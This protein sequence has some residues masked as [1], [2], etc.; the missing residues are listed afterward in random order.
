MREFQSVCG[1]RRR[2]KEGLI[3]EM[4][5][6]QIGKMEETPYYSPLH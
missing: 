1:R 6:S 5:G 3:L 4:K 2:R